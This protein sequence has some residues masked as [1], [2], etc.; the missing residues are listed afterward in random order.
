LIEK[1]GGAQIMARSSFGELI[2]SGKHEKNRLHS[3]VN[4]TNT[5][6]TCFGLEFIH[7]HFE[8]VDFTECKESTNKAYQ[9]K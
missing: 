6:I 7:C 2:T 1:Y 8:E 5:K 3:K 9:I 4:E